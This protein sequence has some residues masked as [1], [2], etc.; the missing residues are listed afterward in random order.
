MSWRQ[1]WRVKIDCLFVIVNLITLSNVTIDVM[2]LHL[3]PYNRW[4]S[5][6]TLDQ[7]SWADWQSLSPD[8][9]VVIVNQTE[10]LF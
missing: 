9:P 4:K 3:P 2:F 7:I 5:R 1:M 6:L 10:Q 8:T